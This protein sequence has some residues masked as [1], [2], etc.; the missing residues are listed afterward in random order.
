MRIHSSL[1]TVLMIFLCVLLPSVNAAELQQT[2]PS[3]TPL[4]VEWKGN[5]SNQKDEF[6]KVVETRME[7]NDLWLR[8]FDKPAPKVDFKKYV[9]ACVFL[10]HQADWLYSI[11]FDEP[12]RRGDVWAIPYG[13]TEIVLELAKPYK[14]SG[15]YAMKVF[16]KRKGA[17]MILEETPDSIRRR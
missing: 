3:K 2:A 6:I 9:V 16:A 15:Q 1:L 7:W 17:E 8:A 11:G 5:V 12:V 4:V 14:A 13:L 10:G